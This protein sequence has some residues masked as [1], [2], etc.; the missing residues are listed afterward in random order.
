MPEEGVIFAGEYVSD[1]GDA[2]KSF[3]RDVFAGGT[4]IVFNVAFTTA[5]TV[6]G[7]CRTLGGFIQPYQI[8][9]ITLADFRVTPDFDGTIDLQIIKKTQ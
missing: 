5:Y 9:N 3:S 6:T 2:I 7:T 4:D 8:S 1:L